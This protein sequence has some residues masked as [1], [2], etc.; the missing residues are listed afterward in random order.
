[1]RGPVSARGR[2]DV[3]KVVIR[4]LK[5]LATGLPSGYEEGAW[6]QLETAVLAVQSGT[7]TS[8][9]LEELYHAVEFLCK[10]G[11]GAGLYGRLSVLIRAHA[12]AVVQGLASA[13]PSAPVFLE[14]VGS[15]WRAYTSQL[16]LTR[17]IFM[18][19]DCGYLKASANVPG[20]RSLYEL[21]L[22]D[23]GAELAA[24]PALVDRVVRGLVDLVEA[25]R[26]GAAVDGKLAAGLLQA[27]TLLHLYGPAFQRP[28]LAATLAYYTAEGTRLAQELDVPAYLLHAERRLAEEE[29]RCEAYLGQQSRDLLMATL[30]ASL[31]EEHMASLLQRG[32]DALIEEGRVEDLSRA[33]RLSERIDALDGLR[34][35]FK[36]H[37]RR[38]GLAR[39]GD[40]EREGTLVSDLLTW[41]SRLESYVATAFARSEAFAQAL[42]EAFEYF[43]NQRQNK[44][45]ELIAKYIDGV[46]RGGVKGLAQD[47]ID[48][49]LD[50]VLVLFR[51]IQG[52]DVFEA[53]YKKDLAKR[54]LLGRSSSIDAEKACISKLK[55]ECGAQFTTKLEGMFKDV[56]L[57]HDVVAGFRAS[58]AGPGAGQ[59]AVGG[60]AVQEMGVHV[61][62]LGFWPSYPADECSLP[63]VLTASQQTFKDF[64]LKKHSGRRLVWYNSLGTC[65]LRASFRAGS[66]ELSVSL[67]QATVL[68]Q[69]ERGT[70]T[71][72]LEELAAATNIEDRELRRT[73]QSLACGKER[74][75]LKEPKGREVEDGDR[76]TYNEGYTSRLFRV[77]INSIQLRESAEE[78]AKT[79]DQVLQDRQYQ[80][81]AA[82]VRIMK[83]RRT[84]SHKLLVNEL[85]VQLKFPIKASD[86]KKRIESL[87]EREYLE[88]DVRDAQIYNYLA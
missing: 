66:K 81:D 20:V 45:A 53:F 64:Y 59:L 21:G 74:V 62:T 12:A 36:G 19:L 37:V 11:G 16:L 49:A 82:V 80:V 88:R 56:E 4:P 1:M 29:A 83:T 13:P 10:D 48:S 76:F 47:D 44:P 22:S 57:S 32:L 71:L 87:I 3:R 58:L 79:N 25:D 33:Y 42:K 23:F 2:G 38:V 41:R 50:A 34:A 31:L 65:V 18:Y 30:K 40:L 28:L 77:K 24:R 63:E 69:F 86:L 9:S 8:T 68:M 6:A 26:N 67:F 78:S 61:L 43:I 75:L 70:D 85:M 35:A 27:L 60:A 52:K 39:V 51:Y 7:P 72:S 46:M 17:Q 14:Q 54:L 73:L 84:L 5:R 15:A 55:A